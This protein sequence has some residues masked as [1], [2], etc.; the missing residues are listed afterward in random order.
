MTPADALKAGSSHTS[1]WPGRSS[2]PRTPGLRHARSLP[3]WPPPSDPP[4]LT[5]GCHSLPTIS[6]VGSVLRT[7]PLPPPMKRLPRTMLNCTEIPRIEA[8][9]EGEGRIAEPERCLAVALVQPDGRARTASRCVTE[10][11]AF[12]AVVLRRL[13][14]DRAALAGIAVQ[15]DAAVHRVFE[16]IAGDDV[17]GGAVDGD[18]LAARRL[19]GKEI[20]GEVV[21]GAFGIQIDGRCPWPRHGSAIH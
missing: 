13:V 16:H 17:A 12:D 2:R 10:S 3:R 7:R 19:H 5:Q 11:I 1:S 6:L 20:S 18:L 4:C 9:A 14:A 8:A 15:E 21:F